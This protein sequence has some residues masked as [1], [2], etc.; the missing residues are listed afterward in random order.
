MTRWF[1]WNKAL[2]LGVSLIIVVVA[3][4][5]VEIWTVMST[6]PSRESGLNTVDGS[7]GP[8]QLPSGAHKRINILILGLDDGDFDNPDNPRRSDTMIVANI[9]PEAKTVNLLSIPRDSRVRIPGQA[10]YDKIAHAF[11]YGGPELAVRTVESFLNVPIDYYVVIDWQAFIKVT[12]I[13]GGVD[14]NVEH[15]MNYD[16]PYENLSI[17]LPKGFQ[18]LDGQKSGEYV[19][20][21]HDELGDIGRVQRQGLFLQALESQLLQTGTIV[22]LPA[23]VTALYRY[24]HTDMNIYTMVKLA[25][26]LKDVRSE[27]LHTAMIPGD[28]ATIN[29]LSYWV[30]DMANTKKLVANM[31][32]GSPKKN[33][34]GYTKKP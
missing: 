26:T 30:P 6:A 23:L 21:R 24:V 4:I 22:K 2:L 7:T 18:H 14:L 10:G 1:Y 16:D 12:D 25:E 34:Y 27:N 9:D 11:F 33:Q 29:D 8:Q 31:L 5:S 20:F 3:L 17:H 28:F 32:A 19:R 15:A 13:L